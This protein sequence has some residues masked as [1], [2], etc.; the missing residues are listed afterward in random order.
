M[1]RSTNGGDTWQNTSQDLAETWVIHVLLSP[2]FGTDNTVFVLGQASIGNALYKST[3]RGETWS[4]LTELQAGIRGLAVLGETDNPIPNLPVGG[5][6]ISPDFGTDGTLFAVTPGIRPLIE[7]GLLRSTDQ[8]N[9]WET[10]YS[11]DV[12]IQGNFSPWV[13][14]SPNFGTDGTLFTSTVC[15]SIFRSQ[16]RGE[17]WEEATSELLFPLIGLVPGHHTCDPPGFRTLV[18]PAPS[19]IDSQVFVWTEVGIFKLSNFSVSGPVAGNELVN[20]SLNV[21][22]ELTVGQRATVEPEELSSFLPWVEFVSVEEDSRCPL[23]VVCVQPGRAKVNIQA[24]FDAQDT[25]IQELTLEVGSV[26]AASDRVSGA[27]G[28]YL[29]KASVLDPYPRT[30]VQEATEYILTLNVTKIP[31]LTIWP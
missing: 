20:A 8:G 3:D 1:Y 17:T 23:D 6:V 19:A 15:E 21:P 12:E 25:S 24:R 27:S 9:T 11:Y 10:V 30:L 22:F 26:D 18:F 31:N 5:I 13:V 2:S 29:I 16:D 28:V 4:Q 14:V 7:S